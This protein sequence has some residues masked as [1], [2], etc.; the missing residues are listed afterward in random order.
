[1]FAVYDFLFIQSYNYYMNKLG[2]KDPLVEALYF[3]AFVMTLNLLTLLFIIEFITIYLYKV[4]ISY[5]HSPGILLL[6]LILI[7]YYR[8]WK[9][10]NYLKVLNKK[11]TLTNKNRSILNVTAILVFVLSLAFVFVTGK[12]NLDIRTP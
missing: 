12:I 11:N 3:V 9:N 2:Y 5:K 10:D 4:D 6:V 7:M 8:Y 1:M